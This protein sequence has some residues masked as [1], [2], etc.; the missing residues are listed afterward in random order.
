MAGPETEAAWAA[1]KY[2][3]PTLTTEYHY[4]PQQEKA[5]TVRRQVEL[6]PGAGGGNPPFPLVRLELE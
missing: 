3:T 4:G 5:L 6:L 1:A 2:P